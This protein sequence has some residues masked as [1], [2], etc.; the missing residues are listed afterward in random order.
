M[1][2]ATYPDTAQ[3]NV[4]VMTLNHHEVPAH[5]AEGYLDAYMT[6]AGIPDDFKGPLFRS[7]VGRTDVLSINRMT[8]SD[9]FRMVKR[10]ARALAFREARATTPSAP[11]ASPLS[12]KTAARSS[13]P[14]QSPRMNHRERRSCTDR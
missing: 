5:H 12:S 7:A 13:T 11:P 14:R 2:S 3:R 9:V 6:A 8:T 4:A 1:G 10:R